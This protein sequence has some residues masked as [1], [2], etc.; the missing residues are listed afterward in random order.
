M[1]GF[2]FFKAKTYECVKCHGF[3]E[4]PYLA[5]SPGEV[6]IACCS[7]CYHKAR[8]HTSSALEERKKKE[9]LNKEMERVY[10]AN[11]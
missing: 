5:A 11:R 2:T 1:L 6:G 7:K 3:F 9:F 10:E 8:M 4:E